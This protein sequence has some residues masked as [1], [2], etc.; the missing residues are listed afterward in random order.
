MNNQQQVV[1][2]AREGYNLIASHY[3]NWKW[4][5]FWR[6]NEGPIIKNWL[7]LVDKKSIGLDA[8][9]GI[10]PYLSDYGGAEGHKLLVDISE[11]MLSL[12]EKNL[13]NTIKTI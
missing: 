5:K 12:A 8:G 9:C 1:Y 6:E 13:K 4:Y 10:S 7:N 11:G 2:K 3:E